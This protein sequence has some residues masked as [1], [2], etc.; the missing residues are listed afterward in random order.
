MSSK[1]KHVIP[2][3]GKW[4]IREA[5]SS[6]ASRTFPTQDEAVE[7]ARKIARIEGATLYIHGKD[8]LIRNRR[9]YANDPLPAKK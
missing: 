9:S 2:S 6:R 7:A 5:G 3:G 1:G 4:S 8:G